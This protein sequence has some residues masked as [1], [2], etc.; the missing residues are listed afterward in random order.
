MNKVW[1]K[2]FE[3]NYNK[4]LDHRSFYFKQVGGG[5]GGWWGEGAGVGRGG[6]GCE[7]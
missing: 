7:T 5:A 4:S 6:G 3:A 2:V 1:R